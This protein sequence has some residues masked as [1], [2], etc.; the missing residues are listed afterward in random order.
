MSTLVHMSG[1]SLDLDVEAILGLIE[2]ERA[3][4]AP[5]PSEGM[6]ERKKRQVRQKI[7]DVANA[8]FLVHGF[9]NVTVAQIAEASDVAEQTLYNYFT[10][11]E[12]MFFD[13]A[14]SMPHALADAVREPGSAPLIQA[15]VQTLD[16][17]IQPIGW[18][19][20]DEASQLRWHR[21][22]FDVAAESPTLVATRLAER[23]R[24]I[25]EVSLALAQ[26]VGGDPA[27]PEVRLATFVIA[28][29]V[30]ALLQ[31]TI[32]HLRQATS[33]DALN[34]AIHRDILRAARLAEPSLTAFDNLRLPAESSGAATLVR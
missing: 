30:D 16:A 20:L 21:R 27:D 31:S 26:R 19:A 5:D 22:F 2:G 7:S 10:N 33:F 18:K 6:R 32:R 28:G 1:S 11:K 9:D 13:R 8:L 4:E 24:L 29:L 3:G 15:V 12:S 25:D 34:D 23:A 14:E 17:D